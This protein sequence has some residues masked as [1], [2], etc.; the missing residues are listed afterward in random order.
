[1][2]KI[3]KIC[4]NTAYN[5]QNKQTHCDKSV[6][7]T[8]KQRRQIPEFKLHGQQCLYKFNAVIEDGTVFCSWCKL[9]GK[10]QAYNEIRF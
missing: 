10:Q 7:R 8:V 5:Q 6:I 9:R 2:Q 3:I 1:M 4:R